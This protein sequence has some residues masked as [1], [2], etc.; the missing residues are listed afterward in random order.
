MKLKVVLDPGATLPTRA[1]PVDAGLDLYS[2]NNAIIRPGTWG[3]FD[4]G[5][6]VAIPEGYVGMVTSWSDLTKF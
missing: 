1:H 6:H 5:V 4:T 2:K 3:V